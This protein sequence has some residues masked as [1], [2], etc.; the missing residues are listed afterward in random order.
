MPLF[1]ISPNVQESQASSRKRTHEEFVDD[2]IQLAVNVASD[3][4]NLGV[5]KSIEGPTLAT[6]H[7][8]QLSPAPEINMESTPGSSPAGLTEPGSSPPIPGSP[9][10]NVTPAKSHATTATAPATSNPT[11]PTKRKLTAAE[12]EQERAEKRQKRDAE[13]AERAKKKAAEDEA[14]AA[15]ATE[16]AKKD[17]ER[18]K[19]KA[20]DE[21]KKRKK[22]EEE[23]AAKRKQEKQKNMLASFVKRAP[24]AVSKKPA[25]QITKPPKPDHDSPMPLVPTK[26]EKTAYNRTFQP[27]FIKSGVTLARSPFEMDEETKGVKSTILD[28]YIRGERSEFNPRPFD[29]IKTFDIP[30]PQRRGITRPSVRKIMEGVYGNRTLGTTAARSESQTERLV[31]S[32]QDQLNSIP[33]KCISFYEDVR[34]PYFG[35]MTT[36]ME[37]KKLL[38]LSRRPVGRVLPLDYDYDSEAEWVEDDGEDLG[39]EEDDEE[40]HDADEE[41]EDFL[42][43]SEDVPTVTRPTFLGEKEP[44]S[45]GICFEDYTRMGPCATVYKYRLEFM[46]DTLEHHSGIDP[47]STSYWPTPH[48]KV[49]AAKIPAIPTATAATPLASMP[50]PNAPTDAFSRLVSGTSSS[51]AA[52]DPKDLVPKDVLSDFKRAI[53]SEELREFSKATIVDLLAKKFPPCTKAQVKTTLDRIAQ[54]VSV[55]GAKKSVKQWA[56]LPAFAS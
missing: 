47:F 44:T 5:Q 21:A 11:Q 26:T 50:P 6:H 31:T 34:P 36:P 35:T 54:R 17:A 40:D 37:R 32:A 3:S 28:E 30:F 25:E 33:V 9:S 46:L 16:R 15:R 22:E 49:A 56:L 39:D 14:K 1:S 41:M 53:V 2:S 8:L 52:V 7:H 42:D 45:T 23:L 18:A 38:A 4:E 43:D 55:P 29:P 24:I 48:K 13:A 19:R 27:F 10:P 51:A 12:R 20:E